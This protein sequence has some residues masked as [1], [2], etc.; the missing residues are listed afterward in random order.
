M[1]VTNI[2]L[3]QRNVNKKNLK[4]P[5]IYIRVILSQKFKH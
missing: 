3:R 1:N 5:K 4:N 2:P